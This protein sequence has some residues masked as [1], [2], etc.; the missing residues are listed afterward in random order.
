MLKTKFD[1]TNKKLMSL[2]IIVISLIIAAAGYWFYHNKINRLTG[3]KQKI[4]SAVATLKV[5]LIKDWYKDEFHYAQVISANPELLEKTERF[6]STLSPVDKSRLTAQLKQIKNEHNYADVILA[7]PSADMIATTNPQITNLS[8]NELKFAANAVIDEKSFSTTDLFKC[9]HNELNNEKKIFI[10]FICPVKNAD[11]KTIAVLICRIDS[12]RFLF[13]LIENWPTPSETAESFIFKVEND[14]ILYLNNLRH[15]MNTPHSLKIPITQSDLP[16][17][18]AANGCLGIIDGK[19]Y[20]NVDVTA[21]SAKIEGTPWFIISKVDDSEL[22]EEVPFIAG[23]ITGF[24]LL[25]MFFTTFA[26][27]FIYNQKQKTIYKELYDKEKK[28]WQQHEKFN[29]TLDSL[30]EGV[31]VI[32]MNSK[33]QY[34]NNIAEELTGWRFREAR[35]R[36]LNEIYSVKNETTGQK[37]NSILENIIKHGLDKELANHTI[38]VSKSGKEIR[39]MYTGTPVYDVNGSLSNIV[40]TFE[41]KCAEEK[42]KLSMNR[43]RDTLDNMLEGCMLIDYNWKYIYVNDSAAKH[44]QQKRENLIGK[45]MLEM[46]PGVEKSEMFTGFKRCMENRVSLQ[47]ESSYTFSEGLMNWYLISLQPVPE[48]IFVLSLDITERKKSSDQLQK[49]STAIEQSAD[50]VMITDKNGF[51]EYVNSTFLKTTGYSRDDVLGKT[52]RILKSGKHSES[53][54]K[55]FWGKLLT[56]CTYRTKFINRKKN[57]ELYIIEKTVTPVENESGEITHFI[58]TGR[59]VTDKERIEDELDKNSKLLQSFF[60][61]SITPFVLLDK[62]FNFLIVNESYAKACQHDVS[63]FI[64]RNHFEF[65]PSDAKTDFEKVVKT[66]KTVRAIERPFIF[67]DHPE[68]GVTYWDWSLTPILDKAGEVEFLVFALKDVTQ[69]KRAIDEIKR[70]QKQLRAL[71]TSIQKAREEERARIAR[72]IHDSIGQGLTGLKMDLSLLENELVQQVNLNES[73]K[74]HEKIQMMYTLLD[75]MIQSVRDVSSRLRPLILDSLGLVTAI[76]WQ[77]EEFQKKSGLV[78]NSIFSKENVVLNS[79]TSTVLFRIFQEC[80]T[81]II[82]HANATKVTVKLEQTE[83]YVLLEVQDNG[84][85]IDESV[86]KGINSLGLLGM[87]ERALVLGGSVDISGKSGRGTIVTV[88]IPK[89]QESNA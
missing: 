5:K 83:S 79:N 74:L 64:G 41:I 47:Y 85:G 6:L 73:D 2:V 32:D 66:K 36:L 57:G 3:Q 86:V 48:G 21:Y 4:L 55:D 19:D 44:G 35:G 75:Q 7:T 77:L 8:E 27:G 62:D 28:I 40:I 58:S 84:I 10:S 16:A 12:N 17:S 61:Y 53:F 69:Q 37:E 80:L 43:C 59:D 46:Y 13:P 45:S 25:G 39:V 78:C 42:L 26:I 1:P 68:W 82:R 70:S 20:R 33:I 60:Q 50:S 88:K 15:I 18:K 49:I 11:N 14:S 89:G 9:E 38:L 71:Y 65:Y 63:E 76:K 31:I 30:G 81:N 29:I 87:K 54:Y 56:G 24:V 23:G 34:M 72:E 22:F 52:P 67:P 51:I